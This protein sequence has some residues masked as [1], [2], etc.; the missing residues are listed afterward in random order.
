M[1]TLA[2]AAT[3][4]SEKRELLAITNDEKYQPQI[5]RLKKLTGVPEDENATTPPSGTLLGLVRSKRNPKKKDDDYKF[6]TKGIQRL[7][8]SMEDAE[9]E[10]EGPGLLE[11]I[12]DWIG[13][14]IVHKI[15]TFIV[16][17]IRNFV[18][19]MVK[20]AVKTIIVDG[21]EFLFDVVVEPVMDAIFGG[22]LFNPETW[23]FLAVLGGLGVLGWYV[24]KEFFKGKASQKEIQ[25]GG[26]ALSRNIT[27]PHSVATQG[28]ALVGTPED[29][30]GTIN[31]TNRLVDQ[32]ISRPA[33][34]SLARH[35]SNAR[36]SA[37]MGAGS[38]VAAGPSGQLGALIGRGEGTYNSVNLGA[39]HNYG[40]AI[41]DLV[42]MT[43]SQVM[44][45]QRTHEFNAVG[46]YQ[47]IGST[48]AGAVQYM[49]LTGNEKF[50]QS[51]QDKIFSEYLIVIKRSAISKYIT[52]KSDNIMLAILEASQEWASVA[53]PAGYPIQNGRISDG[54]I[55][56][57]AGT[58]NNK[59]SIS[60]DEMARTLQAAR[61]ANQKLAT[62]STTP[63]HDTVAMHQG[64]TT[65]PA[66]SNTQQ[67]ASNGSQVQP[68][69]PN[70]STSTSP[71][72]IIRGP[73][74]TIM[75]LATG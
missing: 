33:Q 39:A 7:I 21:T 55:S 36:A 54:T 5:S 25:D 65:N 68:T 18:W 28:Q 73:S 61:I 50:D 20:K 44:E 1:V 13:D 32:E 53:T 57:Y 56:Y 26:N 6:A 4:V 70:T 41:I 37:P 43:I 29:T 64:V 35:A 16:K 24:Y 62:D 8:G 69:T 23:P 58:A 71:R 52:G 59:A 14:K 46:R 66:Q 72:T 40:S 67:T 60:E 34:T 2:Q 42:G 47:M 19:R 63:A 15:R 17:E 12:F 11:R 10:D 9:D 3:L 31:E 51:M 48:L 74:N 27:D 38:P 30:R 45:A 75:S 22:I 49:R